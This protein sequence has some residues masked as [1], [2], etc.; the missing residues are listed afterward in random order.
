M[1]TNN[2]ALGNKTKQL[3]ITVKRTGDI[4]DKGDEESIERH[5]TT[6]RTIT[7]EVEELR[8]AVEVEKIAAEEDTGEWENEINMEIARADDG[9]RA[10]KAWLDNN[11][12]KRNAL[13]R[14]E[15]LEFEVRLHETKLK[16]QAELEQNT[17]QFSK[18]SSEAS[19]EATPYKSG[20]MIGMQAKLPKLIITKFTGACTDC[21][22]SGANFKRT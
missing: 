15:K 18:T 22:G 21:P 10:T 12:K 9:V 5:L 11:Q 6:L 1:A 19:S 4:L 2:S 8:L 7:R 14:E 3:Q 13:E 16:M 17:K 20:S